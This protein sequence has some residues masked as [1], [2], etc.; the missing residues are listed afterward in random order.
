MAVHGILP[1]GR[2]DPLQSQKLGF[3]EN[4][5]AEGRFEAAGIDCPELLIELYK[6]KIEDPS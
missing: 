2:V 3:G 5:N 4:R 6:S 1:P